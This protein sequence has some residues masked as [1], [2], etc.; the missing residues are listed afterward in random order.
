VVFQANGPRKQARVSIL[1]FNKIDFQPKFINCD[2]DRY[3]IFIKGKIHQEKVSNLNIYALKCKCTHIHKRN[4]KEAQNTYW[5]TY[6][7]RGRLQHPTLT[8]EKVI[9]TE[10]K[11][12]HIETKRDYEPN[13]F[14][15][16]LHPKTKEYT[17]SVP[18]GTFFKI[19]HTIGHKTTLKWFIWVHWCCLQTHQKMASDSIRDGFGTS[20][21]CWELHSWP[22]E[23]QSVLLIT[24]H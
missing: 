23:G 11:Q 18:H 7:N 19:D 9:E 2:E 13:G 16:Y 5:S 14:N 3:F 8:N 1:I 22:L 6:N 4:F 10:S 12:R 17:F 20:C 21:G 24:E 15:R